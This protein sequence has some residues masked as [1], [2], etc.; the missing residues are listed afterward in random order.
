MCIYVP[1]GVS[2]HWVSLDASHLLMEPAYLDMH[3]I[4]DVSV[5]LEVRS[6]GVQANSLVVGDECQ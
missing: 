2:H 3:I 5:V 4:D 1:S 6:V